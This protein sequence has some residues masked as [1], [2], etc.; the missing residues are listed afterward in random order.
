M[1]SR[2][3]EIKNPLHSL[4]IPSTEQKI[5][6]RGFTLGE[7][8]IFM[9]ATQSDKVADQADAI[10]QVIN[11]CVASPANFDV[12][13]L[14]SFDLEYIFLKLRAVSVGEVISLEIGHI[15]DETKECPVKTPVEV[16]ISELEVTFD[17]TVEKKFMVDESIGI[18]LKW[19]SFSKL[20]EIEK[21]DLESMSEDEASFHV[22]RSC[23]DLIYTAEEVYTLDDYTTDDIDEFISTLPLGEIEKIGDFFRK[24]PKLHK[25]IAWTCK[26]CG[27]EETIKLEGMSSFLV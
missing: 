18:Q 15:S 9:M 7:Q 23:L 5:K 12:D 21:L 4:V 27:K 8:K 13:G 20:L 22:L 16:N 6:Y 1:K 14:A 10:K 2:L 19:P 3:P 25:D 24:M 11:N 17:E 26:A